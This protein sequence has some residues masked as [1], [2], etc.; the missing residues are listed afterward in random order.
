MSDVYLKPE[1]TADMVIINGLPQLT[2]GLDNA[3]YLSLFMVDW[4]GNDIS[5]DNQ[6]YGSE[7]RRITAEQTLTNQT[8]LDI[9]EAAKNAL[10]WLVETGVASNVDARAEIPEIGRL[11]L[12]VEITEPEH[13]DPS[14]FAY[15]LNWDSQEIII[16][17][18]TW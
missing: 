7:I 10:A 13:D 3:V 5:D 18:S 2:D 12:A 11:Y 8:R 4:W 9:I 15:S 6:K 16:Q 17:E 1:A 14:I